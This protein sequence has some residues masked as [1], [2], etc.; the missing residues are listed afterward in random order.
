ML[1]PTAKVAPVPVYSIDLRFVAPIAFATLSRVARPSCAERAAGESRAIAVKNRTTVRMPGLLWS[2]VRCSRVTKQYWIAGWLSTVPAVR[3]RPFP[4]PVTATWYDDLPSL[5]ATEQPVGETGHGALDQSPTVRCSASSA[6]FARAI[7]SWGKASEVGGAPLRDHQRL[8]GG[9]RTIMA[10]T[11]EHLDQ[12]LRPAEYIDSD[13]GIVVAFAQQRAAGA[14][15][16]V[17]R[18]VTLYYAVRDEIAYT[19][20]CDFRSVETYRASACLAR[21]SG[22]CVAK[23]ALL[24]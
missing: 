19:P 11:N 7:D 13:A 21:G 17:A 20:Y 22:F 6:G 3:L 8:Q 10:P 14:V 18:A 4:Q 12:F 9:M 24:A 2:R 23:S 5:C 16:L 1:W 15:D